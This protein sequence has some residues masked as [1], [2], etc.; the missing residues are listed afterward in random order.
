MAY[1]RNC[2]HEIIT[3]SNFCKGCGAPVSSAPP[4]DNPVVQSDN[5]NIPQQ[6][7]S[8]NSNQTQ[9]VILAVVASILVL[10]IV[11]KFVIPSNKDDKV[12]LTN[13]T[14][15]PAIYSCL[16]L[17]STDVE[18]QGS[19]IY[20]VGTISTNWKLSLGSYI[21][22]NF[23]DKNGAII[24]EGFDSSGALNEGDRWKFKIMAPDDAESFAITTIGI[25]ISD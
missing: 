11:V 14:K 5:R 4:T 2:G 20:V 6:S 18:K 16:K 10:L 17:E 9:S 15:S 7:A 19:S 8:S 24:R 23:Y 1:C 25:V 12:K 13:A 3:G 22:I 21:N